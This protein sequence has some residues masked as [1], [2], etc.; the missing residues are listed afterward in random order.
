MLG[1][2]ACELAG[3]RSSVDQFLIQHQTNTRARPQSL[4]PTAVDVDIKLAATDATSELLQRRRVRQHDLGVID[5]NS[6]TSTDIPT[7][8]THMSTLQ[9]IPTQSDIAFDPRAPP[10]PSYPRPY[11]DHLQHRA[12]RF[13]STVQ[14]VCDLLSF[15]V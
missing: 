13:P 5:E 14:M 8:A 12:L 1:L 11:H 10:L 9:A 2:K 15:A 6:I 4:C 7:H 3:W